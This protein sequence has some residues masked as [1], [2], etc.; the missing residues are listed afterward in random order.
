MLVMGGSLGARTINE[1]VAALVTRRALPAK[2]QI[3]HLSGRRDYAFMQA[4]E[5]TPFGENRV[6]L[7]PYLDDLGDAYAVADLAI[8]RA[9]A[10]TIAE[11]AAVALPAIVIPYPHA[12]EDHQSANARAFVAGGGAL[13]LEDSRVDADTLWWMLSPLFE[14]DRLAAMHATLRAQSVGDPVSTILARI[15][16][17]LDRRTNVT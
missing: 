3:L 10:S 14:G 12:A 1:A 7:L 5:R 15:D 2:W 13:L 4:E 16:A 8:C 17:L 11:L 6:V 9:G